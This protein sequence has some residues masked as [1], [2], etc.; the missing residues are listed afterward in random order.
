M[1]WFPEP[2]D[3]MARLAVL[4]PFTVCALVGAAGVVLGSGA[5]A[6]YLVRL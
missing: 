6:V 2:S 5:I 3:G 1:F 4:L